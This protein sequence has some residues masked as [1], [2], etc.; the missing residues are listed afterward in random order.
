MQLF[1]AQFQSPEDA[2][3]YMTT[4]IQAAT[5]YALTWGVGGILDTNSREKFDKFVKTVKIPFSKFLLRH[6]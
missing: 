5:V 3:K 1:D 6:K 2:E 4:W